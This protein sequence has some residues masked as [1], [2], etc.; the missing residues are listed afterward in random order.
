MKRVRVSPGKFVVISA[1]MAEKA[2]RVFAT[3]LTREQVR[4]LQATEPRHAAGLIIGL[5]KP[6]ALARPK[7]AVATTAE[8]IS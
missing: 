5:S 2:A 1:E 3:G 6:L 4:N 8:K 7:V